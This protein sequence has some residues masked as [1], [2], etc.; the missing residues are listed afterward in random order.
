MSEFA[1]SFRR[2]KRGNL[3]REFEGT[4][5]TVFSRP[6]GRFSWCIAEADNS[7]HYGS[8]Y[9]TEEDAMDGLEFMV[10]QLF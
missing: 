3:Y 7:Q 2:S 10:E 1:A 5:L 9:E 6:D 4:T 8:N